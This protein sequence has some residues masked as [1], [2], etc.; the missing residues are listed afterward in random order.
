LIECN[1]EKK[2]NST[3]VEFLFEHRVDIN[4]KGDFGETPLINASRSENI[5]IVKY[6]VEHGAN[7]N[8]ENN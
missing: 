5:A 1:R 8:K 4:E 2:I 6:L 7:V 3:K